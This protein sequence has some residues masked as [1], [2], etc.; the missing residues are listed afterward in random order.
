MDVLVVRHG[1]ALPREDAVRQGML[2]RDRPLTDKGRTRMKRIG[3]GLA[4]QT[5]G[6]V[7]L[8]TSPLRRAM[9]TSEILAKA[10]GDLEQTETAALL[11]DAEPSELAHFL[12]E[13]ATESPVAVVG[14]EP[15]LG[16]WTSYCLTGDARS[17]ARLKKGGAC[18]IRFEDAPGPAKGRLLWL[19]P[20]SVLRHMG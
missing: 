11:P 4:K 13:S 16:C 6:V 9:E 12:A 2:D 1:I 5:P 7:A 15:H 8:I 3:R 18:L 10:Y 20:P 19:L 14:H 17:I